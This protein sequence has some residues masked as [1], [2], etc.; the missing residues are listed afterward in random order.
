MLTH[1]QPYAIYEDNHLLCC[2]KPAGMLV[3][4]DKTGD[5]CLTDWANEYIRDKYQKP[6]DAFIGLPHRLDRPVSGLVL[7]A[8]TSKALERLNAAFREREIEKTYWAVVSRMP[9]EEKATLV[10]WLLKDTE[11]N[12]VHVYRKEHPQGQR[13]ELSYEVIGA[14]ND[15]ILLRVKPLTGRP[16]QIR[17]QL[18]FIG[19][20]IVGDNKYGSRANY[21]QGAIMLHSRKA[22]MLHPVKKEPFEVVAKLPKHPQWSNFTGVPA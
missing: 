8:R 11:V 5:Y 15:E 19:C 18:A 10:H 22:S 13:A 7:L 9:D 14:I 3:Q 21:V 20:P 4:G 2:Y 1:E 17:S 16:H 6:G 12:K